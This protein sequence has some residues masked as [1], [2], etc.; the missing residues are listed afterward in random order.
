MRE[1]E[2]GREIVRENEGEWEESDK[3]DIEKELWGKRSRERK[4]EM[5]KGIGKY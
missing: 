3:R 2:R 4:R 5:E 1:G